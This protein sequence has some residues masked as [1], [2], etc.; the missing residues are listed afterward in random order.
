MVWPSDF[1]LAE[2]DKDRVWGQVTLINEKLR[3][4]YECLKLGPFEVHVAL[5]SYTYHELLLT[6]FIS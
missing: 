1:F 3:L 2:C 4:W 5:N 6:I